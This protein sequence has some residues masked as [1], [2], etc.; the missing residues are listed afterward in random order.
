MTRV[1]PRARLHSSELLRFLASQGLVDATADMGD[2]GV[3]R[4]GRLAK[5]HVEHHVGR[6]AAHAGQLFQF[7]A[8]AGHHAAVPL[9]QNAA[10]LQQVPGLAFVE[11]N[12]LDVA[13]QPF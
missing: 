7:F 8:R 13:L 5:G 10:S 3:H 2:V 6:F 9:H 11:A 1:L 4:H 12:R